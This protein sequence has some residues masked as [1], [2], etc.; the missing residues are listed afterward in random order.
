METPVVLIIFNRPQ[1]TKS[2][3]EAIRAARPANLLVVADGPRPDRQDESQRCAEARAVIDTVDW[4]CTV[5]KNYSGVNLGCK[6][7]IVSGLTWAFDLFEEA[8]V[9]EDDVIPDASFFPYCQELLQR[10]RHDERVGMINGGHYLSE[11]LAIDGS[12]YFSRFGHVWGWGSWRRVWEKYDPDL[13]L[14]PE[15]RRGWLDR[16][17]GNVEVA[18]FWSRIFEKMY[19]KQIDTWDYQLNFCL[20]NHGMC[21]IAPGVNMVRNLGFGPDATHTK[22]PSQGSAMTAQTMKFPLVHPEEVVICQAADEME[23]RDYVPRRRRLK[24]VLAAFRKLLPGY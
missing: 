11:P 19:R 7:R 21:A 12:Y 20:W 1:L 17:F 6:Q 5:H 24:R 9:L 18:S 23:Y 14:W 22:E 10:Y 16:H 2:V 4:P 8:I 15:K 3:F 13:L